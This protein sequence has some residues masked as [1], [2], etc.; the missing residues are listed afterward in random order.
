MGVAK[1]VHRDAAE[2]IEIF[3]AGG[4]E[5]VRAAAV[6]H[7]HGGTFVGRQKKFVGVQQSRIGFGNGP[8]W[9][10]SGWRCMHS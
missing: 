8:G 9:L 5:D 6:G 7:H 10:P 2:K 4:V 1:S 3:L